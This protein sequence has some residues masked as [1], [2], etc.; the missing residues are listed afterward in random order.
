MAI[1]LIVLSILFFYWILKST[2][3]LDKKEEQ[4]QESKYPSP[5]EIQRKLK[6]Q[7][8][9]DN[10][11][12]VRLLNIEDDDE[13]GNYETKIAGLQHYCTKHDEGV[14]RGMIFNHKNNKVDKNAMAI[15]NMKGKFVGYIPAYELAQYRKW[16]KSQPCTCVGF[17]RYFKNEDGEDVLFG[18]VTAI[19]PC[20][21]EFVERLTEELEDIYEEEL[22]HYKAKG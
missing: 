22:S 13:N 12:E 18:R 11:I 6:E 2:G 4:N 14:F 3:L 10:A 9:P 15:A 5:S 17:I 21:M 1:V 16:S 20:N 7:A 19:K 8:K